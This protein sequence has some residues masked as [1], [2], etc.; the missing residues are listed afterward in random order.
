MKLYAALAVTALCLAAAPATA[1]AAINPLAV[2]NPAADTTARDTQSVTTVQA[3]GGHVA[4]AFK[5]SGS[6]VSPC[7]PFLLTADLTGWSSSTD[8]GASFTDHGALASGGDGDGGEPVLAALDGT[9]TVYLAT[10]GSFAGSGIEV[11]KSIDGGAS[12]GAPVSATPGG[13]LNGQVKEWIDVD[14][15]SGPGAGN[16]YVCRTNLFGPSGPEIRL[17]RSTDGGASF[18]PS[19]G[20]LISTGGQGCYVAVGP[21]H[22]VYVLYYRG[23]GPAGGDNRL[24]VRRSTDQG[25]SFGPEHQLAD[26]Q[27]TS[28]NGDLALNGGL[29]SNSFPQAAVNPTSGDIIAVYNDDTVP[30]PADNGNVFYVK[31]TDDGATWSAPVQVNED[32]PGDQFSPTVAIAP[33]GNRAMFGYYSRSHDPANQLFHRRGRLA[34]INPTTASVAMRRSFQLGPDTPVAARRGHAKPRRPPRHGGL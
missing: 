24:W 21:D 17:T 23:T 3:L 31:S 34:V 25:L 14:G 9:D 5:D 8:S 1:S 19:G 32:G 11:S 10:R 26:L 20:T 7:D 4:V 29:R 15:F 22:G 13:P 6:C 30:G 27:T 28:A 2:N 33:Q 16:V 18:G 12:F